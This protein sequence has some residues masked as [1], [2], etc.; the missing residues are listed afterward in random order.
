M[1]FLLLRLNVNQYER[2]A[3]YQKCFNAFDWEDAH[4]C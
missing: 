1:S 3:L 2:E 4:L